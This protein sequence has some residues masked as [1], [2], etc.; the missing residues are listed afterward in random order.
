MWESQR[1]STTRLSP[2]VRENL[3]C[4]CTFCLKGSKVDISLH[5]KNLFRFDSGESLLNAQDFHRSSLSVELFFVRSISDL[6]L[7]NKC[8]V[9][10]SSVFSHIFVCMRKKQ[11]KLNSHRMIMRI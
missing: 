7:T 11:L 6:N 3:V 8:I 5:N 10:L 1:G 9:N 4:N 2:V